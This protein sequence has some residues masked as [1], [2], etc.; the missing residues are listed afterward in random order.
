MSNSSQFPTL[1]RS[2]FPLSCRDREWLQDMSL[3]FCFW[4]QP[5][6]K[7]MMTIWWLSI[8]TP[9]NPERLE[10]C[11]FDPCVTFTHLYA[12]FFPNSAVRSHEVAAAYFAGGCGPEQFHAISILNMWDRPWNIPEQKVRFALFKFGLVL[13]WSSKSINVDIVVFLFFDNLDV[14]TKKHFLLDPPIVKNLLWLIGGIQFESDMR[15]QTR[16]KVNHCCDLLWL[17]CIVFKHPAHF[18]TCW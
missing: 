8:L 14:E 11:P 13:N 16:K 5:F 6:F 18:R 17:S 9:K 3:F 12:F 1:L 7:P 15:D 2:C 10:T 4:F